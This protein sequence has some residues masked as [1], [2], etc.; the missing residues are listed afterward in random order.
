MSKKTDRDPIDVAASVRAPVLD[1][2]S[3]VAL[4]IKLL[5]IVPKEAPPQVKSAARAMRAAVVTLQTDWGKREAAAAPALR[6]L[7]IALDNA[8]SGLLA[9]L[10]SWESV[11]ADHP[12]EAKRAADLAAKIFPSRLDF[13]RLELPP[14]WAESER[15]LKLITLEAMEADLA[16]LAGAPFLASLRNAHAALGR[17][18]GLDGKAAPGDKAPYDLGSD[19]RAALRSIAKYALQLVAADDQVDD[20]TSQ[21]IRASLAA[22]DAS[23]TTRVVT[24]PAPPTPPV[25]PTTPVPDVPAA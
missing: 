4:G 20:T 16:K 25:T 17:A 9:R 6:P 24:P 18:L 22:I 11:A 2:P 8:W 10:E 13:T 23:R 1:V 3:T 15:R 12:E 14:E 7:D 21:E 5:G 19:L